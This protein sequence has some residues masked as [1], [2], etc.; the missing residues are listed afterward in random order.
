MRDPALVEE[1]RRMKRDINF[2][3]GEDLTR[4][5]ADIL[6]APQPLRKRLAAII[7]DR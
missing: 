5:I 7:L 6:S 3:S 4:I 2:S 1:A